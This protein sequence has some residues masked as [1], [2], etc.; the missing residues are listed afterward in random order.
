MICCSCHTP[1]TTITYIMKK[2]QMTSR[3][4]PNIPWKECGGDSEACNR[5]F[6]RSLIWGQTFIRRVFRP[7]L[8][9]CAFFG[10]KYVIASGP[11]GPP[12][13]FSD[14]I[15]C[16]IIISIHFRINWITFSCP[17]I[18]SPPQID[19]CDCRYADFTLLY[20]KHR[21]SKRD[22]LQSNHIYIYT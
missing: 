12:A 5:I 16:T 22:R 13:I 11:L 2:A 7:N 17:K 20:L 18:L 6:S 4:G 3:K 21:I 10:K 19:D 8:F 14:N 9:V 1:T 15:V